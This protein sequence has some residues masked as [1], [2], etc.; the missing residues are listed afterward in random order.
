VT[1]INVGYISHVISGVVINSY[2]YTIDLTTWTVTYVGYFDTTAAG[3]MSVVSDI[4]LI[5]STALATHPA[6][7][8]TNLTLYPNPVGSSA[9]LSFTLPRAAHVE[10]TV[11]DALGRTLDQVDA[12]QLAPGAQAVNWNRHG[13]RSG[14][15]FF[16]LRFDGQPAGTR[17][18]VL[19]D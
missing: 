19:T 13:Q 9:R 8:A 18:V 14:V 6:A 5:P 10:L 7:L 11:T 16:C 15:Y 17:Q 2:L 1:G 12:G 3:T 4:A